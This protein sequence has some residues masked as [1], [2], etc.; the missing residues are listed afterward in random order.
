MGTSLIIV[1][2]HAV[3]Y[4]DFEAGDGG[5]AYAQRQGRWPKNYANF[6]PQL[7]HNTT[8]G[9][10]AAPYFGPDFC[11]G[12]DGGGDGYGP[13]S[14]A[15]LALFPNAY[16]PVQPYTARRRPAIGRCG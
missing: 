11:Y 13:L 7:G 8:S 4:A 5:A 12:N 6:H 10:F 16:N 1:S 3:E 2:N 14:P 9:D 15:Y